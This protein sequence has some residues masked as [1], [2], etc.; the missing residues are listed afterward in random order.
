M[1]DEV[2]TFPCIVCPNGCA[3]TVRRDTNGKITVCGNTC[4]RGAAFGAK[5]V[6]APTRS[7][8]TTVATDLPYCPVLPVKTAGELPRERLRE[9]MREIN[10]FV[11]HG[12]ARR[13]DIL[14]SNLLATG[15]A[16]VAAADT[17]ACRQAQEEETT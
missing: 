10:R 2:F 17:E 7:L 11:L 9:A 16:L 1:A 8:T 14:I 4:A 3:L 15:V 13:G 6:T 12:P 5:E